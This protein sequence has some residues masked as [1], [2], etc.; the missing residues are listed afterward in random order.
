M[1]TITYPGRQVRVPNGMSVLEASLR[2]NV[3]H[4]SVCG[5]RARC[6]TCRVRVVSDRFAL[7]QP[8]GREAFVLK[9]VGVNPDPINPTRLSVTP[10]WT[11]GHSDFAT[12][13][14]RRFCA[15]PSAHQY[16]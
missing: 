5:G 11:F 3:P 10:E 12:P 13:Y 15:R 9:R 2:Y 8:S 7:P 16:R 6:S 14:R 4:A 1:Y